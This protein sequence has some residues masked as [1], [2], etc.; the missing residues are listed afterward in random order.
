[1]VWGAGRH[2]VAEL[3][4]L[5]TIRDLPAGASASAKPASHQEPNVSGRPDTLAG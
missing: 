3:P 5:P 1:M 2:G 4:P